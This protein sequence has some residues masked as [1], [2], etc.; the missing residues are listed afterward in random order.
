MEKLVPDEPQSAADYDDRSTA[1]VKAVLLEIGQI[2]GSFSGKFVV[3]GGVV[4]S[5]L[6]DNPQMPHVGTLDVDL[7]LDAE[8][9]GDG[10]YQRL[11][12]ALLRHKYAQSEELRFF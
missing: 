12:D 6:L 4:P 11:V 2:L 5:L 10:E 7:N 8:A 9:L 3:I 1:A